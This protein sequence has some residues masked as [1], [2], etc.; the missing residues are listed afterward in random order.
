MC[1]DDEEAHQVERQDGGHVEDGG[2]GSV[3]VDRLQECPGYPSLTAYYREHRGLRNVP[4]VLVI[5][6]CRCSNRAI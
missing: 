5:S 4:F 1:Q 3:A 2:R 6:C